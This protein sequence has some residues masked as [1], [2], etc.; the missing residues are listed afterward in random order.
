M[1]FVLGVSRFSTVSGAVENA[2]FRWTLTVFNTSASFILKSKI[3]Q[4][5]LYHLNL[6]AVQLSSETWRVISYS[7][8]LYKYRGTY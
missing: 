2:I 7:T 1:V 3:L 5:H 8:E 4:L 6:A